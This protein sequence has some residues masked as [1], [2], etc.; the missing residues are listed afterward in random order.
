METCRRMKIS[1]GSN[2]GVGAVERG[3][4][5]KRRGEDKARLRNVW[6]LIAWWGGANMILGHLW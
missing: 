4:K 2:G 6:L 5:R 1:C 3:G